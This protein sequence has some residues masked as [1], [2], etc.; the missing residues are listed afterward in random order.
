MTILRKPDAMFD[1]KVGKVFYPPLG[2]E[3]TFRRKWVETLKAKAAMVNIPFDKFIG[4]NVLLPHLVAYKHHESRRKAVERGDL[5]FDVPQG[6][7]YTYHELLKSC[8]KATRFLQRVT[9]KELSRVIEGEASL[10]FQCQIID[11]FL[12]EDDF[13]TSGG[14]KVDLEDKDA[15]NKLL[16]VLEDV[17]KENSPDVEFDDFKDKALFTI[18]TIQEGVKKAMDEEE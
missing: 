16:Q 15:V 10:E 6:A 7:T 12:R 13:P 1:F 2:K 3:V 5:A 4:Y 18:Q 17:I 9:G 11:F 8:E 14:W